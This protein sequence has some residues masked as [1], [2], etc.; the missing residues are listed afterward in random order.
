MVT[1]TLA[2]IGILLIV[3]LVMGWVWVISEGVL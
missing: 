3:A 2:F 1:N